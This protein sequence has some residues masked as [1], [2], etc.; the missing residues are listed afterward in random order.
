MK[1]TDKQSTV[2]DAITKKSTSGFISNASKIHV[3]NELSFNPVSFGLVIKA[4]I[5][6]N[7]IFMEKNG[8][9][10]ILSDNYVKP[11]PKKSI[12]KAIVEPKVVL[13]D[14]QDAPVKEKVLGELFT[15]VPIDFNQNLF[16]ELKLC[17]ANFSPSQYSFFSKNVDVV[18]KMKEIIEFYDTPNDSLSKSQRTLRDN[19]I[20]KH[21][22]DMEC[23][24][25]GDK[26]YFLNTWGIAN[27]KDVI[28]DIIQH[29]KKKVSHMDNR[30]IVE[31]D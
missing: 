22:I 5:D 24:K 10:H 2:Y 9:V 25:I 21:N 20:N 8:D 3:Q 17:G 26:M 16:F 1:L 30:I 15:Y 19:I 4:L 31:I 28:K 27:P 23:K 18:S 29:G 13:D 6:K 14:S 11:E 7:L 12:S